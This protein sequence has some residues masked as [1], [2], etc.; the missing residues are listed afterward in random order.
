MLDWEKRA[1]VI[2]IA[3]VAAATLGGVLRLESLSLA[4]LATIGAGVFCWGLGGV[5]G[6]RVVFS[7]PGSRHSASY[8][9]LA[10]RAWGALLCLAG[11]A[12]AGLGF[13]P[14]LKPGASVAGLA[15]SPLAAGSG[16]LLGGLA[17]MLYAVTLILGRA[18]GG[19]SWARRV[20]SL[21]GRLLGLLM[22]LASAAVA[23]T[24]AV[25]IAAP[26]VYEDA[27]RA[28]NERLPRAP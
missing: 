22:L 1:G 8:Y 20:L 5:L 3:G 4:G 24:G 18:E 26:Q 27:V 2:S 21:P 25:R 10:A 28:I 9:G 16:M 15:A 7:R 23:A 14:L 11:A 6:R 17:G 19:D 13:T 12:V